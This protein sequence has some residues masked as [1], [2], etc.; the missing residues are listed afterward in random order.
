MRLDVVCDVSIN[1]ALTLL[2]S[3]M[4]S[5]QAR[6][7][8]LAIGAQESAFSARR[9]HGGGPAR[10]WWQVEQAGGVAGVLSH[11]ASSQHAERACRALQYAPQEGVVWAALEHNDVLAAVFA[12]LLLW[13]LPRDLPTTAEEGW[14]QSLLAWR[15]GRPHPQTW[16]GHWNA[17]AQHAA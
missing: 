2:P 9:Q 11:H 1:P 13:T 10:G 6:I 8:L 7:M 12:R 5:T 16:A 3:V 4:D 14:Q 15:P 17:A